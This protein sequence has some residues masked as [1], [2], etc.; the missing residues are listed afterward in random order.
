MY[1]IVAR[2]YQVKQQQVHACPI[3]WKIEGYIIL[4]GFEHV[5]T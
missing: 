3:V 5:V 1:F 2:P 4:E